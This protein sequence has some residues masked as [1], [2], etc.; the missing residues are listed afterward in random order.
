MSDSFKGLGRLGLGKHAL[1]LERSGTFSRLHVKNED[2]L[3]DHFTV[4]TVVRL[5]SVYENASV[6]TIVSR[7]NG[8]QSEKGGWSLGVTSKKSAYEPRNVIMQLVGEDVAGNVSYAVVDSN[9]EAPLNVPMYIAASVDLEA[10]KPGLVTFYLKDLSDP[11][12]PM[13]VSVVKHSITQ[14]IQQPKAKLILG[15]RDQGSSHN[16]DGTLARLTISE[17]VLGPD[18]LLAFAPAEHL[19]RIFDFVFDAAAATP[20]PNSR[21]L[22]PHTATAQSS[23][24]PPHVL[25]AMTDFCH[26]LLISNEFLYLH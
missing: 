7:W 14:D 1:K 12:N 18:Q 21:W 24:A 2:W 8:S 22:G 10:G 3:D 25:D 23:A 19:P 15:G 9:L 6:N 13:Q 5:N 4:E 20:V 16:W 11:K 26:A 17:A